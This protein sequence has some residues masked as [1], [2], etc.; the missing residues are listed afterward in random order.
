MTMAEKYW[1]KSTNLWSGVPS[2]KQVRPDI[3]EL[4]WMGCK[5]WTYC[6]RGD[7]RTALPS[8]RQRALF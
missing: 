7:S 8:V 4:Q 2:H 6:T 1:K 3:E 5:Q